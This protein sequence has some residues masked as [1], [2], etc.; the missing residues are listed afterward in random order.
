MMMMMIAMMMIAMSKVVS[1]ACSGTTT[2]TYLLIS[3]KVQTVVLFLA[4]LLCVILS[5]TLTIG[6]GVK[7]VHSFC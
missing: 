5:V 1:C 4:D 3:F 7:D 6:G 2:F